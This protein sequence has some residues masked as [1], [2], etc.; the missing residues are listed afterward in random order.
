MLQATV[1]NAARLLAWLTEMLADRYFPWRSRADMQPSKSILSARSL[2]RSGS[3]NPCVQRAARCA[4]STGAGC[5]PVAF[6]KVVR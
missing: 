2:I 5:G 3:V 6:N 4:A 1:S